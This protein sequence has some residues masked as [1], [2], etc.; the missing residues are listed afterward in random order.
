MAHIKTNIGLQ[1]FV[2][3]LFQSENLLEFLENLEPLRKWQ[4]PPAAK[5]KTRSFATNISAMC[6]Q[7]L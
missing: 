7:K 6:S 3:Y 2:I 5:Q 4:L 1:K